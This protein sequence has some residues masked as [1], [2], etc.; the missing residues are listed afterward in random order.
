ML[1]FLKNKYDPHHMSGLSD[2]ATGLGKLIIL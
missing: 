2:Y 1:E